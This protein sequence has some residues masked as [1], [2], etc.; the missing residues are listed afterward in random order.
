MSIIMGQYF[1]KCVILFS[2]F[3]TSCIVIII[4]CSDIDFTYY[5][6]FSPEVSDIDS[7]FEPMFISEDLF[8]NYSHFEYY[9][10]RFNTNIIDEWSV[11]LED[12]I[13]IKE[14]EYFLLD[15][16]STKEIN[17]L[18]ANVQNSNKS[19]ILNSRFSVI[20]SKVKGFIQFL[21]YAKQIE[22]ISLQQ[23]D[24]WDIEQGMKRNYASPEIIAEL[25]NR[26]HIESDPFLKNRYW[27]QVA[28]AKYYSIDKSSIISFFDK[29]KETVKKNNL[30]YRALS[31]VAG[32]HY[33][34][35][36]YTL[37]N[38]LYSIVYYNCKEMRSIAAYNF[39]PQEQSDFDSSLQL[40][41]N[42]N[43]KI[44]LWTLYGYYADDLKAIREI[45]KLDTKNEHI[46]FLLAHFINNEEKRLNSEAELKNAVEYKNV[47]KENVNPEAVLLIDSIARQENTSRPFLWYMGAGYFQILAGNYKLADIYLEKSS[48]LIS[49]K[50]LAVNQI[51]LL[52]LV[53][54][55]LRIDSITKQH[56]EKLVSELDW[57]Y[58]KCPNDSIKSF[59][60]NHTVSWSKYYLSSLYKSQGNHVF[61]EILSPSTNYY[62]NQNNID[63][64]IEYFTK[65][66][67]SSWDSIIIGQYAFTLS[68]LYDYVSIKNTY[69]YPENLDKAIYYMELSQH[70]NDTLDCDP[71]LGRIKDICECTEGNIPNIRFTKLDLLRRMKD[72]QLLIAK[73]ERTYEHYLALG[74]AF[75]NITYFGNSREFYFNAIINNYGIYIDPLYKSWLLNSTIANTYFNNALQVANNNEQK[76]LCVYMM[77]KCERNT[78]YTERYYEDG[79][80]R[81]SY[82]QDTNYLAWN[83]F[84]KLKNEYSHTS[85]YKQ[86]IKE[87]GYFKSYISKR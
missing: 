9:S 59:R 8:Y 24:V 84:V 51:R 41:S 27:F 60:Y 82:N 14:I 29:T 39:H 61:S 64:M 13:P 18:Y 45:S 65:K 47:L 68:D 55:I 58:N 31:Y 87:C 4:A 77:S 56:E 35:R 7:S 78:F 44:A 17:E 33:K 72:L 22:V 69:I 6:H 85:F 43:E 23:L 63:N 75:Y 10:Q 30:Y 28:K 2:V 86:V 50:P 71:F 79:F 40:A 53:N 25:E 42:N 16:N 57:L 36:N 1:K 34:Q 81:D 32:A 70:S 5:S 19:G 49:N 38:Y 52:Q 76:A 21:Y 48:K 20:D 73:G 26:Y 66:D 46:D 62:I 11:Y 83:G 74:N 15:N 12:R 3:I 37:S 54:N 67:M 80:L